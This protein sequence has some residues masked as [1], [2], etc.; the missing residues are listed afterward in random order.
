MKNTNLDSSLDSSSLISSLQEVSTSKMSIY[1]D[2]RKKII[3]LSKDATLITDIYKSLLKSL[4]A[5]FSTFNYRDAQENLIKVPC[6]YGSPER[7]VAKLK[8]EANIILPA[9][10]VYRVTESL[11]DTRRRIE[12][13]IVFEKYFDRLKN[14]AIRVVSLAPT[15]TKITYKISIWTKYQ[16]DMD[17]LCEQFRRL[18]NPHLVLS[19]KYNNQIPTY[20][21]QEG[22]NID[23]TLADGQDR[24]VRRSFDIEVATYIPNPK[25]VMTNT[26][27]IESF[28]T[29]IHTPL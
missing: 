11:D 3:S 7:I 27:V 23:V 1:S 13:L 21:N 14:R 19:T 29:E 16:E 17:Q 18:F 24:I 10:S 20:I 2:I 6:W 28:N 15:P 22:S 8:Q 4:I 25:F 9:M 26:G 12:N 5:N